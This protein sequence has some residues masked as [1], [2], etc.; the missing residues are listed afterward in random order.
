M[1]V[2]VGGKAFPASFLKVE[3]RG[4]LVGAIEGRIEELVGGQNPGP[5]ASPRSKK[6]G[7][8]GDV[9]FVWASGSG[10]GEVGGS[11]KKFSGGEWRA[12][13][14][15]RLLRARGLVELREVASGS[16][17][18]DLWLKNGKVGSQVSGVDRSRFLGRRTVGEIG[19]K[20]SQR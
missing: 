18:Q 15:V 13:E 7:S 12:E 4:T 16:A 10:R 3:G 9:N 19:R 11:C 1:R 2:K 8:K 14:R 5:E 6:R 20:E 17:T